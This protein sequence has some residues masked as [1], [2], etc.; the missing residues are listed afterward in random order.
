M[1]ASGAL[2][3][4]P[5]MFTVSIPSASR[6]PLSLERHA[7]ESAVRAGESI[8][9]PGS[10]ELAIEAESLCPTSAIRLLSL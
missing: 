2:V 9:D 4:R 8:D 1:T 5:A 10:R 6:L 7:P 3:L